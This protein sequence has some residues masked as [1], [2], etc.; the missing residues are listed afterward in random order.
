MKLYQEFLI[1]QD[2]DVIKQINVSGAIILKTNDEGTSSILLIQRSIDDH[3][4]LVW[5]FPRGK[6]DKGDQ[7]KLIKCLKREVKEE[8][9]LDI[10]PMKYIDK[11]EY[12]ADKGKRH[13]TQFNYL[14]KLNNPD[15]KVKLSK[16]HDD[17]R[18]VYSVGEIELLVPSEM[19]KTISK[20]LNIDNSIVNYPSSEI[21]IGEKYEKRNHQVNNK[22][23]R[24]IY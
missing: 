16:E 6:C 22:A 14:C 20:V 5:E 24:I 17:Y 7:D 19:K 4:P 1:G 11:Y 21:V 18:W 15:Q 12:I 23:T 10:T 3:W 8:T 2:K 13:S 9:G